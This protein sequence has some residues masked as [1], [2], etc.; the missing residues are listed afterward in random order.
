[1]IVRLVRTDN[2]VQMVLVTPSA[3]SFV[4]EAVPSQRK[5]AGTYLKLG[6]EHILFGTDHL[7][8]VLAMLIL[9]KGWKRLIGTITAFT[10]AHSITLAAATL[11]FVHVPSP[12]IEAM[13]ALSIVFVAGEIIHRQTRPTKSYR[14]LA[15]GRGVYFWI[16]SWLRLRERIK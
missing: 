13:I 10:V 14:R 5:V 15:V 2:V 4:V 16:A 7:L 12:P 6:I 8:F 9:V 1:M 3:P 11:G